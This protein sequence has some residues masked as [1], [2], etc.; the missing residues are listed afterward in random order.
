MFATLA[1]QL[2]HP[3]QHRG[4]L[5]GGGQGPQPLDSVEGRLQM[6]P[7]PLGLDQL[8]KQGEAEAGVFDV[9][10]RRSRRDGQ[11]LT[12]EFGG[13]A[14]AKGQQQLLDGG[15]RMAHATGRIGAPQVVKRQLLFG[16]FSGLEGGPDGLF[17]RLSLD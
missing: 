15:D 4:H 3:S 12:H 10:V 5:L 13:G 11:R 16:G 7:G 2:A 6:A 9:E 1:Q 17:V 14:V 8:A